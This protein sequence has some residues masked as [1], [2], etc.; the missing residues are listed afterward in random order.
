MRRRVLASH[1]LQSSHHPHGATIGFHVINRHLFNPR[2]TGATVAYSAPFHENGVSTRTRTGATDCLFSAMCPQANYAPARCDPFHPYYAWR[3]FNPRTARVHPFHP[4]NTTPGGFNSRTRTGATDYLDEVEIF[5]WFQP[6]TSTGATIFK[7][8]CVLSTRT[9]A[10][11]GLPWTIRCFNTHRH[12]ATLLIQDIMPGVFSTPRTRTGATRTTL[13][14]LLCLAFQH[15]PHGCDA[16]L[17]LDCKPLM[18]QP[19]HSHGCD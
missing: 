17:T 14:L 15:A 16:R 9:G 18:F 3:C 8:Q 7:Q 5:K 1:P 2:R 11:T 6:R 13:L 10:T 19:T 4:Y 12:G